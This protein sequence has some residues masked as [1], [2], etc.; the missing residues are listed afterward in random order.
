MKANELR[1]NN[2][3]QTNQG[4]FKVAGIGKSQL[5]L[6][7]FLTDETHER[8][9]KDCI[10]IPLT[11]QWLKDFGFKKYNK[12]DYDNGE[13]KIE[14]F[15]TSLKEKQRD[16]RWVRYE[17]KKICT[18]VLKYV[19]QLQNLCFALTGKELIKN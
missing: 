8:E 1:R 3:V 7:P 14:M 4:I 11:E 2:L 12:Y 18:I 16:Y 15:G 13:I 5:I 19:H 9:I 17:E 10:P 6:C